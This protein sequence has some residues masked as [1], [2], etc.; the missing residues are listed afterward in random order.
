MSVR[1]AFE[2]STPVGS[3]AVGAPA[4]TLVEVNLS[5]AETHSEMLLPA[6]DFALA[7]GGVARSEVRE[8]VIGTGPGSFTGVRIAAAVAKGWWF[9]AGVELWGYPTL[10]ALAAGAALDER[11]VC[12]LL[13]ARRGE[14]Y[15]ACYRFGRDGIEELLAPT[16]RPASELAELLDRSGLAPLCVGAG[17]VAYRAELEARGLRVAAGPASWPR[18]SSLLW[19]RERRPESGRIVDPSRW[20]P[21]YV[22]DSGARARHE[23]TR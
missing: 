1:L 14:V 8:V 19:L 22:R 12:A 6:V 13:D 23:P 2:T 4:G 20:E 16:A 17:A 15:G 10:L 11:P 7:A 21:L 18:A 9:A 3:V 5:I